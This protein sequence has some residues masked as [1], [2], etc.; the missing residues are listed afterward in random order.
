MDDDF[1]TQARLFV[2]NTE[3]ALRETGDLAIPLAQGVIKPNDIEA[4]LFSL[5]R[6][7]FQLNRHEQDITIF[8][9][10]GHAL[11]DLA[12]AKVVYQSLAEN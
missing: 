12:A 9:S 8:K 10:V 6:E 7:Q 11:E 5:T 1:L 2:D 3:S 4:D